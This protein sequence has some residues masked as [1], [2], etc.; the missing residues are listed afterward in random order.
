MSRRTTS[1]LVLA[2]VAALICARLGVWQL[3][4]LG[5]RRAHNASVAARL[6]QPP[7]APWGLPA[8]TAEQRYRRVVLA[9]RADYAHEFVLVNR[10]RDGS[11]GVHIVTPVRV[12]GRDTVVLLNRGWIYSPNGTDVDLARWREGDSVTVDGY[13]EIPSRRPGPGR[14]SAERDVVAYRWLDA[15]D[16][17]RHVGAP[18]TPY[19]V[20]WSAPPGE[21]QPPP[22]RPVRVPPPALDEGSHFSYAVQW[23]SFATVAVVGGAAFARADRRR[24]G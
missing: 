14:L 11:P 3:S 1:L 4:R 23:F 2:G 19:Y 20:V 5:E 22:D 6:R 17:A 18:V 12:A 10:S 16:V 21:E 9:G 7:V 8:D 24:R 13:V 15:A